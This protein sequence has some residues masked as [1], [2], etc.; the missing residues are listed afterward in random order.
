MC[1]PK[2]KSLATFNPLEQQ[3][4]QNNMVTTC[5]HWACPL[6]SSHYEL[7]NAF[8]AV[9]LVCAVVYDHPRV[10]LNNQFASLIGW[11]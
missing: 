4:T 7:I 5:F 1:T 6:K 3:E 9:L 8:K 2:I 11:L 10:D